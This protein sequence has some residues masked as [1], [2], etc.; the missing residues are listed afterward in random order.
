[1]S[2]GLSPPVSARPTVLCE[3]LDRTGKIAGVTT[4]SVTTCTLFQ[5]LREN[6]WL[7]MRIV[8]SI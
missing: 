2:A 1:M 8:G 5:A 7:L 4:G 3:L 6:A